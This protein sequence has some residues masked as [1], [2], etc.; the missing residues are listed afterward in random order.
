MG[1]RLDRPPPSAVKASLVL[2]SFAF[3]LVAA[4]TALQDLPTI[5]AQFPLQAMFWALAISLSFV[6]H[7]SFRTFRDRYLRW[8]L[9]CLVCIAIGAIQTTADVGL[10]AWLADHYFPTW[11]RWSTPDLPRIASAWIMYTWTFGLNLALFTMLAAMEDSRRQAQRAAEAE[12][13]VKSA[14]LALLRLQLNPHFLFNTLN[15][16]SGLMLEG[17]IRN[18]DQM[19][20]RLSE[21]LRASLDIDPNAL[22]ALSDELSALEAYLEIEAVRFEDRLV[23]TYDCPDELRAAQVPSFILQPLVENAIKHAVEPAMRRVRLDI[24]ARRVGPDLV[25]RVSDDGEPLTRRGRPGAGVGLRNIEAR[26]ATLYGAEGR[27]ITRQRATG[28]EAELR[29]PF[30][31]PT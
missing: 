6:L 17:D 9:L 1:I 13:A 14:Q 12:A 30:T 19:V 18:A 5:W 28:F 27:S 10:F 7:A 3:V 11:K 2:W 4:V 24:S 20:T 22:T 23:V 8:P 25:L 21:F 26:L 15:A 29:L 16:I 31:S